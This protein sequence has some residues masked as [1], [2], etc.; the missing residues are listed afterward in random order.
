MPEGAKINSSHT[1]KK[2]NILA[3]IFNGE[4]VNTSSLKKA[5]SLEFLSHFLLLFVNFRVRT[6]QLLQL[7]FP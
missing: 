4:A 5:V 6:V 1:P 3:I 2:T 7:C